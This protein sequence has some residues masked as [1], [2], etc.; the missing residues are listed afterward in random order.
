MV[1]KISPPYY[2]TS[3]VVT[4]IVDERNKYKDFYTLL[5][6]ELLN[7]LEDYYKY[8]GNP[9]FINP[10]SLSKFTSDVDNRK[11]SLINLYK[12]KENQSHYS[13]LKNMRSNHGLNFCPSCGE[14]GTPETLDHYLPKDSFPELSFSPINLVPMC[15]K[16]QNKKGEDYLSIN[17]SKMFLHP[18]YDDCQNTV[19]KINFIGD[20]RNPY[21]EIDIINNIDKQLRDTIICHTISLNLVE[22]MQSKFKDLHINLMRAIARERLEPDPCNVR[23]IVRLFMNNQDRQN[24]WLKIYYLSIS[25]DIDMIDFLENGQLPNNI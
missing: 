2:D 21:F 15:S 1:T 25:Q 9:E 17:K 14:E 8:K 19:F 11:K 12:P 24:S 5:K 16:C 22:R 10:L 23:Q 4:Q 18:Y 20:F 6:P 7:L 13:V 3:A